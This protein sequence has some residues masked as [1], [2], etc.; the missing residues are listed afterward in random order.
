MKVL[1]KVPASKVAKQFARLNLIGGNSKTA[2][3]IDSNQYPKV[4][5]LL[6]QS[7]GHGPSVGLRKFWKQNLPTLKF[8]N[9]D[10]SFIVN[11][12]QA[13]DKSEEKLLPTKLVIY[14]AN[15]EKHE[16]NVA[17]EHS[18]DILEKLV[19]FTNAQSI[20]ESEIPFFTKTQSEW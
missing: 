3:K 2:F 15:S 8:H 1:S 18:S 19:K 13:N 17:N 11:R 14:N 12:I 6:A 9:D 5:L 4:E 7:R 20:P 16:I 10:I